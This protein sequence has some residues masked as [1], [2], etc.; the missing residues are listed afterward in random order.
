MWH[1][2]WD[3]GARVGVKIVAARDLVGGDEV[4]RSTGSLSAVFGL[5]F[6]VCSLLHSKIVEQG[7]NKENQ[8]QKWSI[9]RFFQHKKILI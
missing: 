3:V 9:G 1:G 4:S 2:N 6:H 7:S 5:I 8:I